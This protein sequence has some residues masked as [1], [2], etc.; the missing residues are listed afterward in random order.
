[1]PSVYAA[2][3][4]Y[5]NVDCLAVRGN[6]LRIGLADHDVP[7]L[8]ASWPGLPALATSSWGV[9]RCDEFAESH[10]RL[11]GTQTRDGELGP[12]KEQ[13]LR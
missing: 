6:H 12:V 8:L 5:Q 7:F 3:S 2:G 13:F 11:G 1:V 4:S 9:E 10:F